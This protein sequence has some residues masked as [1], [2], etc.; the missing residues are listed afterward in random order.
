MRVVSEPAAASRKKKRSSSCSVRR[1]GVPSSSTTS[2]CTSTDQMSST[3][4]RRFCSLN[5]LAYANSLRSVASRS[6]RPTPPFGS[7]ARRMVLVPSNT[8]R[9]SSSGM[10]MMSAITC[11]GSNSATSLTKS[12]SPP[13]ST[14]ASRMRSVRQRRW[15]SR[16]SSMRGVKPR[17]TRRRSRVCGAPSIEMSILPFRLSS[18]SRICAPSNA[19]NVSVSRLTA[20]RSAWREITQNGFAPPSRNTSVSGCFHTGALRRR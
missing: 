5:A 20:L 3:G 7:K 1:V 12:T 18:V 9:R 16:V 4:V 11:N 17:D 8:G 13:W 6:S 10:P 19:V 15:L 2:A 14:T